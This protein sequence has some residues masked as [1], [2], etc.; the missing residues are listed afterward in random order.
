VVDGRRRRWLALEVE[1][2]FDSLGTELQQVLGPAAL[3]VWAA[4]MTACKRNGVQGQISYTSESEVWTVL[5]ITEPDRLGFTFDDFLAVT[6]RMKQTRKRP[7]GRVM[8]VIAT[9]WLEVNYPPRTRSERTS[10]AL[11]THHVPEENARSDPQNTNELPALT[12]TETLTETLTS[13]DDDEINDEKPNLDPS[14]V[15]TVDADTLTKLETRAREITDQKNP[16]N[17]ERYYKTVLADLINR[18]KSSNGHRTEYSNVG[19]AA[20]RDE[21]TCP[22]VWADLD[23][24]WQCVQCHASRQKAGADAS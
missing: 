21:N 1:F 17:P 2:P 19:V 12:L 20:V 13:R 5:G 6:G 15:A 3:G 18:E 4:L 14:E 7:R 10:D 8:D 23:D 9:H 11:S 24:E 16:T 22:H